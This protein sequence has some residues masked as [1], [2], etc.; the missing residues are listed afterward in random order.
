MLV[1]NVT[2]VMLLTREVV[3][4]MVDRGSG[5]IINMGSIAGKE[6]YGGVCVGG[7]GGRGGSA[8]AGGVTGACSATSSS[9]DGT[10]KHTLRAHPR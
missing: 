1:T 9:S 10:L 6:A 4:G 7:G 3:K 2:S 8:A 5:H